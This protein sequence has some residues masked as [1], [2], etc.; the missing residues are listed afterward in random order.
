MF[1]FLNFKQRAALGAVVSECAMLESTLDMMISA[2]T[3]LG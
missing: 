2:M 3:K 1:Q